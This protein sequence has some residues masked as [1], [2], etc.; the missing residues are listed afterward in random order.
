MDIASDKAEQQNILMKEFLIAFPD[1]P[2][3]YSH[4]Q[5]LQLVGMNK[6]VRKWYL[7]YK[8][9]ISVEMTMPHW[10]KEIKGARDAWR[11]S[12]KSRLELSIKEKLWLDRE[13][14]AAT[15]L[16][17]EIDSIRTE[18]IEM[19]KTL[20]KLVIIDRL[21]V[22]EL[23]RDRAIKVSLAGTP[24]LRKIVSDKQVD[25][26]KTDLYTKLISGAEWVDPFA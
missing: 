3:L 1:V 19:Y 22:N 15:I 26:F 4:Q 18:R 8:S 11:K 17:K 20:D 25:G 13:A 14:K 5:F 16:K 12:E 7:D 24:E 6:E 2:Q 21:T 10:L 23:P 9:E